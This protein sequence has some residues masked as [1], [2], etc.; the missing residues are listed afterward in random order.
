MNTDNDTIHNAKL[1]GN[2]EE[3]AHVLMANEGGKKA[4]VYINKKKAI[5][6]IFVPGIMGTPL[7]SKE[8]KS[9]VKELDGKW[10]WFPDD[11]EWMGGTS[12]RALGFVPS[13]FSNLSPKSRSVMLKKDNVRPPMQDEANLMGLKQIVENLKY[14]LLP[15]SE[16]RLRGW[17]SVILGEHGYGT[18]LNTLESYFNNPSAQTKLLAIIK[19][20]SN[21]G[22]SS[23]HDFLSYTENDKSDITQED[24]AY[25]KDQAFPVY[26]AG[27]NWLESNDVSASKLALRIDEVLYDCRERLRYTCEKAILVTHSMGGL[28][29]RMCAKKYSQKIMGIVHGVQPVN[30]AGSAYHRVVTGWDFDWFTGLVMGTTPASLTPIFANPGPLELLPNKRYGKNWL[31]I[32]K[33]NMKNESKNL[34]SLPKH[35][36][37][38]EIYMDT[39]SWWRV[40][41]P[42]YIFPE[43]KDMKEA[44]SFYYKNLVI[45]ENFH[46]ELSDFFHPNSHIFYGKSEKNKTWY[47][48]NINID[49]NILGHEEKPIRTVG[50]DDPFSTYNNIS[51]YSGREMADNDILK[52]KL[53]KEY[54]FEENKGEI[55]SI[56]GDI[57]RISLGN[58]D[59]A[60][61]AT[62]PSSSMHL[63]NINS[64]KSVG[65]INNIEHGAA[66][67]HHLVLA[68]T[69][70]SIFNIVKSLKAKV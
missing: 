37:Y 61:D 43:K 54:S 22:A 49:N 64:L 32:F 68:S 15:E 10:A 51:L 70:Y 62:V 53:V 18:I 4:I 29:A 47:I 44:I 25:F 33:K 28:V 23:H 58:R 7:I 36:P 26:A 40:V 27:Y 39:D 63:E 17:G 8:G 2:G 5:P 52:A 46:D 56:N 66:F 13:G 57:V 31:K 30:G 3:V 48:I 1:N 6:I 16:C 9:L 41:N 38:K 65:V 19:E 12:S 45:A 24:I 67:N 69:I 21:R 42:N 11:M 35:N 60:G 59:D 50:L 14:E 34:F 20:L 55:K